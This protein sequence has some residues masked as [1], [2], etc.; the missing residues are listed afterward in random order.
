[1][2]APPNYS[3][4][5]TRTS[6]S[7][8]QDALKAGPDGQAALE[9]VRALIDRIVPTPTAVGRGFEIE[10]VGEIASM[11]RPGLGE[12]QSRPRAAGADPDLLACSIKLRYYVA[13][14]TIGT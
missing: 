3:A 12:T 1:V 2:P 7:G 14:A 9:A 4:R 5:S 13:P 10:L 11:I 8:L 6:W